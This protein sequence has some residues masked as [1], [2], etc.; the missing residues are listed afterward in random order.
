MNTI[1]KVQ[2]RSKSSS[3]FILLWADYFSSRPGT[4]LLHSCNHPAEKKPCSYLFLNP[5]KRQIEYSLDTNKSWDELEQ[6]VSTQRTPTYGCFSYEFGSSY[7]VNKSENDFDPLYCLFQ[8]TVWVEWDPSGE[9]LEISYDKEQYESIINFFHSST[10]FLDLFLQGKAPPKEFPIEKNT[11]TS[12]TPIEWEE[13]ADFCR[14]V[15]QIKKMIYQGDVY[16][17]NISYKIILDGYK[18]PFSLFMHLIENNPSPQSAF[19]VIDNSK[20]LVSSSPERLLKRDGMKITSQPIKGTRP[21]GKTPDEDEK[22]LNELVH[23][24]KERSELAMITDLVRNDLFPISKPATTRIQ[25]SFR[26]DRY[27]S[28]FQQSSIIETEAREDITPLQ[29]L[30]AVFPGGSITGCPKSRALL[31]I[32]EI[33]QRH[34]GIYT[35]SIGYCI[36]SSH[37]DWNIAIRTLVIDRE[38]N[39]ISLSVGSGIVWDSIPREEY[40]ETLHKAKSLLK[41]CGIETPRTTNIS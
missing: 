2:I 27:E 39:R 17:L 8:A 23:S 28:V 7:R 24:T 18:R 1:E 31:R 6:N 41:A 32:H 22:L 5:A 4:C 11:S 26:I 38:K 40:Q 36:D 29:A 20:T 15:E 10:N 9:L 12:I 33:E 35:G 14:K 37:Y 16:Q 25:E 19:L 3:N 13:E 21:R 34:R 30:R